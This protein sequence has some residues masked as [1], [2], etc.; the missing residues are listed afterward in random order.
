[1]APISH[2]RSSVTLSFKH[3]VTTTYSILIPKEAT[4]NIGSLFTWHARYRPNH[5]SV[6]FQ[7]KRLTHREFNLNINRL[8]NAL[9]AL[10]IQKGSRPFTIK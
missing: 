3:A 2:R 5:L 8:A 10:G 1:M 4:M 7:D 6:V 9:L